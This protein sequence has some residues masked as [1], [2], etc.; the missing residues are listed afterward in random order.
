MGVTPAALAA[1]FPRL[2]HMAEAG[3][4]PSIVRHGLLSTSALLDLFG[5]RGAERAALELAHRP[6][7]VVITHPEHGS[8]VV[9]DQKPMSDKGL[10]NALGGGLTPR[11]WYETLNARVFF[12]LTEERL[13]RLLN[14]EAYRTQRQTV[15][16]LDTARLLNRH[17]GRVQL[18]H[19]NT[20]NT[21]PFPHPRGPDTFRSLAQ[22]PFDEWKKKRHRRDHVVELTVEYSVPDICEL[23]LQVDEV[24]AGRPP[25]VLWKPHAA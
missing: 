2:Y 21:K 18:S 7:S 25:S 5:V 22:Y 23:V 3:S 14:A 6:R 4:W 9:R 15:L 8:A 17:G 24:G 10:R 20:G 1:D 12:W 11:D 19:L 16:T 13:Q